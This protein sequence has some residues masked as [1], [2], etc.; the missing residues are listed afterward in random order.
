[1]SA[2]G[3]CAATY[4]WTRGPARVPRYWFGSR[5]TPHATSSSAAPDP[6]LGSR[7]GGVRTRVGAPHKG[8]RPSQEPHRDQA[9]E[10]H[11]AER[12][13]RHE[14]P[15]GIAPQVMRD[16]PGRVNQPTDADPSV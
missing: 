16:V 14:R 6:I 9:V 1:M 4:A 15:D 11:A 10:D 2:Y 8:R 7:S 13:G 5:S 12:G 3:S